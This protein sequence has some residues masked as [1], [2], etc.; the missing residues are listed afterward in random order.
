MSRSYNITVTSRILG[1]NT[2][3]SRIFRNTIHDAEI[4][5]NH[6]SLISRFV[7]TIEL[8][9]QWQTICFQWWGIHWEGLKYINPTMRQPF[10]R[11]S[12]WPPR[13]TYFFRQK[14]TFLSLQRLL[15]HLLPWYLNK[16]LFLWSR[17]MS[18]RVW[19]ITVT[20]GITRNINC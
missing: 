4:K 8:S 12:R 18:S 9:N 11:N 14:S 17:H 13:E 1:K 3:F 15:L 20:L 7:I 19:S 16:F 6:I 10:Q 2:Y 5:K